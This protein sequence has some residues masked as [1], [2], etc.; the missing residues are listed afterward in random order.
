MA[1]AAR[2][3]RAHRRPGRL[4]TGHLAAAHGSPSTTLVLPAKNFTDAT[5]D[6]GLFLAELDHV[7]RMLLRAGLADVTKIALIGPSS[8][9]GHQLD[10]RF[11]QIVPGADPAFELRGSCGHSIL[12]A[13]SVAGRSGELPPLHPGQRIRVNV[14][15]NGDS[16]A[17]SVEESHPDR[18][19]LGASF[20][21]R[22]P[23]PLD[24]L[25]LFGS[26]VTELPHRGGSVEVTGASMGNPYVFVRAADLGV[27]GPEELFAAGDALFADLCDLRE[28]AQDRLGWPPGVF[29]KIAA[30]LPLG[31]GRLAARAVSVPSWHPTLAL[32]G[33]VCLA[34]AA[35]V[36][37]SLPQQLADDA[38][39][40]TS[41][42]PDDATP[43]TLRIRT[44]G[45]WATVTARTAGA[46]PALTEVG[47]RGTTVTYL[48]PA[49][50]TAPAP[51]GLR[52]R[53]Y[54]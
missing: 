17:C 32:T 28:T 54:A 29:P 53:R 42:T 51:S 47:V 23:I 43:G 30:L 18:E 21:L 44:P 33:A 37:G 9:P 48:G 20:L 50:V 35:R 27:R 41:G 6:P 52:A 12:A 7:R 19:R 24:D 39:P 3:A 1:R 25:L 36:P 11:V 40:G 14:L 8:R 38:T 16:V 2:G 22:P 49:P 15:N 34:A 13:C 31:P 45:R 10:Y 4:M 46:D 5:R 26:P